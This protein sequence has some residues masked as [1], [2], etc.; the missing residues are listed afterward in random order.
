MKASIMKSIIASLILFAA[1]GTLCL[2]GNTT[3]TVNDQITSSLASQGYTVT[4]IA[5]SSD[6]S[7]TYVATTNTG[8]KII[9]VPNVNCVGIVGLPQ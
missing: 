5:K 6:G 1:S 7:G 2:A 4:S 9:V 3:G 8:V